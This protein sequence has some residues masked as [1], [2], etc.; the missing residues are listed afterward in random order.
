MIL[1]AKDLDTGE[2]LTRLGVHIRK[3]RSRAMDRVPPLH[4]HAF[5]RER[6]WRKRDE[7]STP[8]PKSRR[9]TLPSI[10][11]SLPSPAPHYR[12]QF[13]CRG[14]DQ[15]LPDRGRFFELHGSYMNFQNRKRSPCRGQLLRIDR[16]KLINGFADN[17]D[18]PAEGLGTDGHRDRRPRVRNI[19]PANQPVRP[20]HGDGAHLTSPDVRVAS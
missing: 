3:R 20:I 2:E 18:N 7:K 19:L 12:S 13:L 11:S 10:R 15:S 16:P 8:Y 9:P 4:V 17:V 1:C 5:A 14:H 6:D